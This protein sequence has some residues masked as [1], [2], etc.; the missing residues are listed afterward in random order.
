[1]KKSD[2]KVGQKVYLQSI[3]NTRGSYT[4]PMEDIIKSIGSKYFTLESRWHGRFSIDTMTEDAGGY[5]P[6]WRAWVSLED[7]ED[8]KKLKNY[9][10]A[11][12]RM[13]V[14]D[15]EVL[16]LDALSVI[17]GVV[18]TGS[19]PLPD[20]LAACEAAI[21]HH[22]GGHSEIGQILREAIKKARG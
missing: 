15:F 8:N 1:M 22:Q 9:A 13:S 20:L 6:E 5:T 12:G 7:Y 16:S 11:L 18:K 3:R 19:N 14:Y 4:D 21:L 17:V 2:L 10:Q